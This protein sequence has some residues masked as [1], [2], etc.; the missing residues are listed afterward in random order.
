MALFCNH[1]GCDRCREGIFR[2]S[3][4]ELFWLT[5]VRVR[6]FWVSWKVR[7][8]V[9][10][11]SGW[12]AGGYVS[13]RRFRWCPTGACERKLSSFLIAIATLCGLRILG[14]IVIAS[15]LVVNAFAIRRSWCTNRRSS[16]GVIPASRTARFV[17]LVGS[18]FRTNRKAATSSCV[19]LCSIFSVSSTRCSPHVA[20]G[21][22]I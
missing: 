18:V 11:C 16:E 17:S 7:S 8:C 1:C 5:F 19:W 13:L 15:L 2:W 10:S 12:V 20:A 9:I 22:S 21:C 3:S 4:L 6:G 14:S